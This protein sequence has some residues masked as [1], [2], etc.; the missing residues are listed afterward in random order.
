M[1][2]EDPQ[3]AAQY[4]AVHDLFIHAALFVNVH[5]PRIVL[6]LISSKPKR[7]L[8]LNSNICNK[9]APPTE[10]KLT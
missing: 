3:E 6:N 2:N 8:I 5:Y 7:L 9:K 10:S 1:H 4:S